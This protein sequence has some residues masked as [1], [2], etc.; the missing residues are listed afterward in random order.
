MKRI[1]LLMTVRTAQRG[2]LTRALGAPHKLLTLST[3][4]TQVGTRCLRVWLQSTSVYVL[5][6]IGK[7]R[8]HARA[9]RK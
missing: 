5:Q 1:F 7:F 6:D 8:I 4:D 3:H 2:V 9:N